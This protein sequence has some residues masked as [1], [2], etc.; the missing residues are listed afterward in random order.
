[1]SE[2]VS[3]GVG[4][5]N[6]KFACEIQIA[7]EL[8]HRRRKAGEL[9]P[10]FENKTV[11]SDCGNHAPRAFRSLQDAR[12]DPQPSQ[13]MGASQPGDSRTHYDDFF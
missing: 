7:N 9:R 13:P 8:P 10:S 2:Y 11:P 6:H 12:P 5:A 1:M 3:P 4:I